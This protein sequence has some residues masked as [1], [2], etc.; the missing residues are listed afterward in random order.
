M[1]PLLVAIVPPGRAHIVPY[2]PIRSHATRGAPL[3]RLRGV[4]SIKWA[5]NIA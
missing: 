5:K 1:P 3:L 4:I 2:L